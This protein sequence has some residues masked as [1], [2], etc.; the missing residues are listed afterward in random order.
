ME[1][2][3]S[4]YFQTNLT[5]IDKLCLQKLI[6]LL[7]YCHMMTRYTLF[8]RI[9]QVTLAMEKKITSSLTQDTV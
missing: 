6:S 5:L 9:V 7:T 3:I 2:D 8:S 1:S 4:G